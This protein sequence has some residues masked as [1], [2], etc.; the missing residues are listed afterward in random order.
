M[1]MSTVEDLFGGW[2]C[3]LVPIC[4]YARLVFELHR[5]RILLHKMKHKALLLEIQ[6]NNYFPGRHYCCRLAQ[7]VIIRWLEAGRATTGQ[8][9]MME[10]RKMRKDSSSSSPWRKEFRGVKV[11]MRKLLSSIPI[12]YPSM[13]SLHSPPV[14]CRQRLR[15]WVLFILRHTHFHFGNVLFKKRKEAHMPTSEK[16]QN[17]QSAPSSSTHDPYSS[18]AYN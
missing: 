10:R 17:H 12:S 14:F 5:L 6:L 8:E 16:F 4:L 7:C 1:I 2:W 9:E 15:V 18:S 13:F 11:R 3:I